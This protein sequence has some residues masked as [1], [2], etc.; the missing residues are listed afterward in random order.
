MEIESV[1]YNCTSLLFAYPGFLR[2]KMADDFQ[3]A[4]CRDDGFTQQVI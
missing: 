4:Q 2:R 1:E 3:V